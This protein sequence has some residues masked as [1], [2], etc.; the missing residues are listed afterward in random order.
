MHNDG[1]TRV[2]EGQCYTA[3]M[4]A[5]RDVWPDRIRPL[6]R[7]EYESLVEKGLLDDTRVELLRGT[8]VDMSHQGPLHAD[9]VRR[10]AERLIRQL[11]ADVQTRTHSP[12]ALSDDSEPEPDIAVVLSGEYTQAHPQTALLIIEVADS[13]LRKDRVV[14][15]ALYAMAGIPEL[16]LVNLTDLTVEVHRRP[17]AGRYADVERIDTSGSI[18]PAEFPSVQIS[19]GE[20][21]T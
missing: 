13:S 8:L 3:E 5:Q 4:L 21:L 12:L 18:S 6:R 20:L 7:I 16:W 2:R 14:K 10:L 9:V 17:T 15:A 11:P 1:L 19:V